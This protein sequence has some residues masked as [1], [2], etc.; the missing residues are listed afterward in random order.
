MYGGTNINTRV[1]GTQIFFEVDPA[2]LVQLD[3]NPTLGGN[4]DVNQ[5]SITNAVSITSD[6]FVG[7]LTGLVYGVDVRD[8][9]GLLDGFDFNGIVRQADNLVEWLNLN[10][11]VD[12]GSLTSPVDILT[13]FG[14][15][16]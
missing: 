3:L 5:N 15:L 14:S 12:Y 2:N 16:V 9:N 1:T 11:D 4:L 6:S 10:T 13:D 8:L 7:D